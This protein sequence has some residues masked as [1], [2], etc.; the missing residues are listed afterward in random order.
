MEYLKS[1][2]AAPSTTLAFPL[3]TSAVYVISVL[4]LIKTNLLHRNGKPRLPF[5]KELVIVHNI[6][7]AVLSVAMLTLGLVTAMKGYKHYLD[8]YTIT[9]GLSDRVP[10]WMQAW[11]YPSASTG[12]D[13]VDA[14]MDTLCDADY[15]ALSPLASRLFRWSKYYEFVDTFILLSRGKK[16]VFLHVYHHA[17]MVPLTHYWAASHYNVHWYEADL[18]LS[19]SLNR[20][21]DRSTFFPIVIRECTTDTHEDTMIVYIHIDCMTCSRLPCIN[22][23]N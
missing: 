6:F 18:S 15:V 4:I 19:L 23:L 2:S 5:F 13:A 22:H 21:I 9:P 12:I 16:P 3:G 8:R 7:L 20:S 1:V 17:V 14:L 11:I 10:K